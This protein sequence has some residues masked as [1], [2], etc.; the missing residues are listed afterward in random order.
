MNDLSIRNQLPFDDIGNRT[1]AEAGD[2]DR[3]V[4]VL[5][6]LRSSD[7]KHSAAMCD[8]LLLE[9]TAKKINH[10]DRVK[11]YLQPTRN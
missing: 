1:L 7:V 5:A 11:N 8:S 2:R 9:V 3:G 6:T 10:G 4:E